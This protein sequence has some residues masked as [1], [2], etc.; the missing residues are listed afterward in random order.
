[1]SALFLDHHIT[2]AEEEICH[3]EDKRTAGPGHKRSQRYHPCSQGSRQ[4]Q[5]TDRKFDPPAWKKLKWT[6]I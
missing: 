3:H 2:K 5:D 4:Q 6:E 1:M